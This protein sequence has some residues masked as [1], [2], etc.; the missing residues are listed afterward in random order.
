MEYS[1]FSVSWIDSSSLKVSRASLVAQMVKN[2]PA[3]QET[4]FQ[5]LGREVPWRGE[6]QLTPVFL[7][8]KPHGPKSMLG[9]SHGIGKCQ[10]WLNSRAHSLWKCSYRLEIMWLYSFYWSGV[11]LVCLE[12]ILPL[13]K[14]SAPWFTPCIPD[15]K[16]LLASDC[17]LAKPS[18]SLSC[19]QSMYHAYIPP[20]MYLLR[21]YYVKDK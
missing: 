2:L 1:W 15:G 11:D 6:W 18:F 16:L 12:W 5:S 10:T 17:S 20:E 4:R 19:S 13:W 9:Y 3:V 14:S 7:P 8:G 21:I